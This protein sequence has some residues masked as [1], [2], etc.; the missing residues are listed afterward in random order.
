MGVSPPTRRSRSYGRRPAPTTAVH[1]AWTRS[2][3]HRELVRKYREERAAQDTV[4]CKRTGE[5]I[6]RSDALNVG[7]ASYPME[8][9]TEEE[10]DFLNLPAPAEMAHD[11]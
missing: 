2:P 3:E 4:V 10:R 8:G 11:R 6:L 5:T 1:M 9:L 7:N